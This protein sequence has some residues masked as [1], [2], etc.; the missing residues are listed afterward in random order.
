M[1]SYADHHNYL[2]AIAHKA[3][4]IRSLTELTGLNPSENS[5]S[6]APRI[7]QKKASSAKILGTA[8]HAKLW[9]PSR[10]PP[11]AAFSNGSDSNYRVRMLWL[12]YFLSWRFN[13]RVQV[14][15]IIVVGRSRYTRP[16]IPTVNNTMPVDCES[17]KLST[18]RCRRKTRKKMQCTQCD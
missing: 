1:I 13:N 12:F 17:G 11:V 15:I 14:N 18:T 10:P 16:R 8:V 7:V 9:A 2:S 6:R 4:A 3:P 5:R